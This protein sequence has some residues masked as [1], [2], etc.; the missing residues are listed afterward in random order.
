MLIDD[1]LASGQDV[2]VHVYVN[3]K[4]QRHN[5]GLLHFFREKVKAKKSYETIVFQVFSTQKNREK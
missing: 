5:G 3:T 1:W 2:M 4:H